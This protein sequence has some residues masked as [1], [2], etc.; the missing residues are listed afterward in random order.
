MSGEHHAVPFK[1]L[2]RTFLTLLFLTVITVAAAMINFSS[3]EKYLQ[4]L[5]VHFAP[6]NIIIAMIIAFIKA[7]L[8]ATFFMG[9]K[10]DKKL[11]ISILVGNVV[12]V[13]IFFIITL[14]D[15]KFRDIADPMDGHK[16]EFESPVHKANSAPHAEHH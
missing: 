15:T 12:F 9:L 10:F 2:I 7:S 1:F 13:F 8:V 11:N 16:L 14:S 6:L 4:P 3:F 5:E